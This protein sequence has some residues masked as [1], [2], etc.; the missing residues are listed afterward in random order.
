VNG[1]HITSSKI[2][3]EQKNQ[4][5]TKVMLMALTLHPFKVMKKGGKKKYVEEKKTK[6]K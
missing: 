3:K 6:K 4:I 5:E 1:L 2:V